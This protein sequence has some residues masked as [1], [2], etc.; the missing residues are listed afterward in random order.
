MSFSRALSLAGRRTPLAFSPALRTPAGLGSQ[1]FLCTQSENDPTRIF[2]GGLNW[3]TDNHG[4]RA[5]LESFGPVKFARVVSDRET[6]R[7]RGF[8]FVEFVQEDSAA[9]AVETGS[10]EV[11]GRQV[12]LAHT[13]PRPRYNP[14]DAPSQE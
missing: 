1:R 10:M 13:K 9:R 2:V 8:G 7:S 3:Q 11:D 4:L 14:M 5:A 6:G 12:R